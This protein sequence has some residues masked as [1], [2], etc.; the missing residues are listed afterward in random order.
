MKFG[1]TI[2]SLALL[3]LL[4][5]FLFTFTAADEGSDDDSQETAPTVVILFMF[6]GLSHFSQFAVNVP[7]AIRQCRGQPHEWSV[8]KGNMLPI[9]FLDELFSVLNVYVALLALSN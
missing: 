6:F 3:I 7:I 5:S 4:I 2:E 8:L 9:F 1:R